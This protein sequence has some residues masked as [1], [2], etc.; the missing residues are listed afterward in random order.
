[1]KSLAE[2]KEVIYNSKYQ[3]Q[4]ALIRAVKPA[5]KMVSKPSTSLQ[6]GKSRMGGSPD[7]PLNL[8]WPTNESGE[9]DFLVQ[10]NL[11][12]LSSFEGCDALP[13]TGMLYIFGS[14]NMDGTQSEDEQHSAIIYYDGKIENLSTRIRN[15]SERYRACDLVFETTWTIDSDIDPVLEDF[16]AFWDVVEQFSEESPNHQILGHPFVLQTGYDM[17]GDCERFRPSEQL[18]NQ[19]NQLSNWQL[20]CQID[21]DPNGPGFSWGNSGF[22][23]FWINRRDLQLCKFE[24]HWHFKQSC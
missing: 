8:K 11:D 4:E 18:E 14:D 2:A 12:D 23:Y 21:S 20:L 15:N 7:L 24:R 3:D 1:M 9:L 22:I 13:S 5:V 17:R 6:L 16:D 10:I 19:S